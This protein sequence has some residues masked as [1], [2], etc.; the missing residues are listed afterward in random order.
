MIVI[1]N[2][3]TLDGLTTLELK[4]L[5]NSTN[6]DAKAWRADQTPAHLAYLRQ[7]L[8]K[9][10]AANR[11]AKREEAKRQLRDNDLQRAA[12]MQYLSNGGT[13]AEFSQA[14]PGMRQRLLNN[15]AEAQALLGDLRN[16]AARTW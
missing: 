2:E 8:P 9:T 7:Q 1:M 6:D 4:H 14:W 11:I 5:L 13:V 15:P 10:E 3:K 12:K 16:R